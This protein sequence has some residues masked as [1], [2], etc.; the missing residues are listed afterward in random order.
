MCFRVIPI[1]LSVDIGKL[2]Y[3]QRYLISLTFVEAKWRKF[4]QIITSYMCLSIM[5]N[6]ICVS[7]SNER[8]RIFN[9]F[10]IGIDIQIFQEVK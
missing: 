2:V 4:M 5:Q 8:A 10:G 6:T 7:R 1:P 3:V 9:E